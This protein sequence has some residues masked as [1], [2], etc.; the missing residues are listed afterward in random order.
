MEFKKLHSEVKVTK[1]TFFISLV[2]SSSF[3]V[4]GIAAAPVTANILQGFIQG[5]PG[6]N[7]GGQPGGDWNWEDMYD[8]GLTREHY[9]IV[10]FSVASDVSAA[11]T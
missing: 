8:E 9:F 2:L 10:C 6:E 11:T 1:A 5:D 7:P 3:S 4:L